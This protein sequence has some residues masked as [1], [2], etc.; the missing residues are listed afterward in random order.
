MKIKK[1]GISSLLIIILLMNNA[2]SQVTVYPDHYL[3]SDSPYSTSSLYLSADIKERQIYKLGYFTN[4]NSNIK[5]YKF[6]LIYNPDNYCI[7]NGGSNGIK[8]SKT[9][10]FFN[11]FTQS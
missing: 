5:S 2:L 3:E 7:D 1:C 9:N 8:Q 10:Q 11:S 4:G 6:G